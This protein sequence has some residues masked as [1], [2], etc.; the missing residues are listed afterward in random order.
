MGG[1]AVGWG[2]VRCRQIPWPFD[3]TLSS[4]SGSLV[5]PVWPLV[6]TERRLCSAQQGAR[7]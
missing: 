2:R 1:P 3:E 5:S 7:T 6:C 4:N